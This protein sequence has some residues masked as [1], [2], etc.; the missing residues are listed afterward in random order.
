[1]FRSPNPLDRICAPSRCHAPALY[2]DGLNDFESLRF[3]YVARIQL[4]QEPLGRTSGL[5]RRS[6]TGKQNQQHT[7]RVKELWGDYDR[8]PFSDT[9][10]F[11]IYQCS[12]TPDTSRRRCWP[13]CCWTGSTNGSNITPS[14]TN[15]IK[16]ST[17]RGRHF[18]L[19]HP[20][21]NQ[22]NCISTQHPPCRELLKNVQLSCRTNRELWH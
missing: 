14:L 9:S 10:P 15:T 20:S 5:L 11:M 13:I 2:Q 3:F 1:M 16:P 17:T 21:S 12:P 4:F 19:K 7:D 18:S 8:S 22:C 6:A